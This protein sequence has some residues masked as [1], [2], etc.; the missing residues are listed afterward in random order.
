[1]KDWKQRLYDS[2]ISS[3]Q[4][5]GHIDR[6]NGLE[7]SQFPYLSSL[8]KKYI[9]SKKDIAV[10]DLA[11]GHGSLVYCLKQ[12]GYTNVQGVDISAEQVSL[13]HD[14]GL[15]EIKCQD[16]KE[17]LLD[18]TNSFDVIFLM[19]ILEHFTKQELF[20]YLDIV[21]L[22]LKQGGIVV[23]HV[24]N[25]EGVFGMRIRFG[26]LTHENCFT[27][28]SMNQALTTCGFDGILCY[29]D[30]PIV[31]GFKSFIR[32]ILWE[33]LSLPYRLLLI[34]ETGNTEMILS[35]NMLVVAR[36]S[37]RQP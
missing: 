16:I 10:L 33:V 23:I 5:G 32:S 15:N 4:A 19:D 7:I 17:F 13:A 3:G 11:C 18:K 30:K 25:G 29:E 1:M 8:I 9:P 27:S 36:K 26:D 24:P 22:S 31:H 6:K 34:A 12:L 35:Q 37:A 14:L 2:Y 20:D 28:Q 21:Y